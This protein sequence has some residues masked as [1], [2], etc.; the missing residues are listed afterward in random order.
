[1]TKSRSILAAHKAAVESLEGRVLLSAAPQVIGYLPDYEFGHF[2][3]VDLSA[4]TQVNYFAIVAG[5][6]GSL[7]AASVDGDSFANIAGTTS[8]LNTL[9]A[10]AHSATTRVS[11]SITV[12][13]STPFLT[14]AASSTA[15]TSF[16][17]NLIAFCS[18]YHLDGID[19]DFEPAQG[20]LSTA[21][22]NQWGSLLAMLHAATSTRGL[23]LSE[24]V[25]VSPPYIILPT[26]FSDIDR[27]LVMDYALEY[28]SSAPYAESLSYL[29][30]WAAYGVPKADLYMG[31]PF[32]GSE[33][34][35]WGEGDNSAESYY[36]IINSYAAANG[37]AYPAASADSVTVNGITWGFNGID[38]IQNKVNYV[39]QNGYGGMMIWELGQDFFTGGNGSYTGES[40]LPVIKS[41]IGAAYE[42]WTGA[43]S[44]AWN[45][46]S[47]WNFGAVPIG[48]TNVVING[49]AVTAS[50]ALTVGPLTLNGGT[51]ALAAGTGLSTVSSLSINNGATLDLAN[52]ELIVNYGTTAD[53]ISTIRA[54]LAGGYNGG[55][56]TGPGVASSSAAANP[57]YALGYAD[58]IDGIVA[59]LASGQIEVKY[60]LYGDVNL[61]GV[62]NGSDFG[63]FSSNFGSQVSAWDKG[64]FNYDGVVNGSDFGLLSANFGQQAT[65]AAVEL[66]ATGLVTLDAA[67][68]AAAL[69]ATTSSTSSS[70]FSQGQTITASLLDDQ[71]SRPDLAKHSRPRK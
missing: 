55:L 24:A 39:L 6:N 65:G 20:S 4:L 33:G 21:Q 48:T 17:N 19:L 69:G 37:G 42:T 25:Q 70:P 40:L 63:I 47:N 18:T 67:I 34:T 68:P 5:S 13:P 43:A 49:G 38:T 71:K 32:Y 35:G 66:P 60:T 61:D 45:N 28:N 36:Q 14:I 2:T 57:G 3:Y 29:S 46:P 7:P 9:V 16:V 12:D 51:L 1:M 59:G 30:N 8:Q 41:T 31:V 27:Y 58:G 10:A 26:Y 54:Y 62:V 44:N 50:S 22:M 23:I 53:P 64:D 15:T 11:V 56:W 52:N